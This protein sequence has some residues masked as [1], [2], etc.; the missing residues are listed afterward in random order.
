MLFLGLLIASIIGGWI[1][2]QIKHEQGK[3]DCRAEYK[4]AESL[5]MS[6]AQKGASDV[7]KKEQSLDKRG[8]VSELCSFGIMR[9]NRGC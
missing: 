1:Y 9:E 5:S 7:K 8:I 2:G 3:E 4:A 6:K